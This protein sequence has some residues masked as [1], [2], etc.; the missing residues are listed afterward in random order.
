MME[1]FLYRAIISAGFVHS[2]NML[3]LISGSDSHLSHHPPGGGEQEHEFPYFATPI[4]VV[5]RWL[6][7]AAET[8]DKSIVAISTV[9]LLV[10]TALL[11]YFT[12]QLFRATVRLAEDAVSATDA[13]RLQARAAVAAQIPLIAIGGAKLV[14]LPAGGNPGA[15]P[16]PPGIPPFDSMPVFT[17]QNTGPTRIVMRFHATKWEIADELV[18][19]PHFGGMQATGDVILSG[20]AIAI[21]TDEKISFTPEQ[22]AG[23]KGKSLRLWAYG[24]IIYYD[25]LDERHD[26]GVCAKWDIE[27]GFVMVNREGYSYQRHEKQY[28]KLLS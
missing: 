6:W 25:F 10:V 22:L 9:G 2:V 4:F 7:E 3:W 15:D 24:F 19:E 17:F 27:R 26:I 23:I 5:F 20:A 11:A 14:V 21:T 1:S 16:V 12:F 28:T 8:N 13:T 18:G